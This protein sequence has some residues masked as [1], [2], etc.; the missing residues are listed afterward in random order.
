MGQRVGLGGLPTPS[1]GCMPGHKQYWPL[2]QAL[3]NWH[4]DF[5]SLYIFCP[6]CALTAASMQLFL[7]PYS[8][9][10]FCCWRRAGSTWN[11]Y[12]KETPKES[13]SQPDPGTPF[14]TWVEH[15]ASVKH[16]LE[17][18]NLSFLLVRRL[19]GPIQ[20]SFFLGRQT[21]KMPFYLCVHS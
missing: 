20:I 9:F 3:Q 10:V 15:G 5:W 12:S 18:F 17:G 8:F 13:T 4:W 11:S 19:C 1:V 2:L 21:K 6:E 16:L 7:V 14:R